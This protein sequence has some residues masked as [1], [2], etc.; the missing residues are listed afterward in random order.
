VIGPRRARPPVTRAPVVRVHHAAIGHVIGTLTI[1]RL[2][3]SE[4]F[5]QGVAADVLQFGPGHYPETHL[6]GEAGT[7]AIAGHRTTHTHPFLHLNDLRA[8]DRIII[9]AYGR[10]FVY[11]VYAMK[12]VR[13]TDVWVLML[14]S[15]VPRLVLTACHPPHSAAFRIVVFARQVGSLQGSPLARSSG[16]RPGRT[17][18]T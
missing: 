14:R 1:P 18:T 9:A 4:T 12:I 10:R 11:R 8:N 2:H 17:A 16:R 3:E 6:P 5:R 13:P 7:V 15:H